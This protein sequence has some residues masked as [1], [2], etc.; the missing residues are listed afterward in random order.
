MRNTDT[1][2]GQ[3]TFWAQTAGLTSIQ[4]P[5]AI[6]TKGLARGPNGDITVSSPDYDLPIMGTESYPAKSYTVPVELLG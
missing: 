6:E 4:L 3:C 2:T 5:G 1:H